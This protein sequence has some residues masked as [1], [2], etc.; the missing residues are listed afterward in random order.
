MGVIDRLG[1][2]AKGTVKVQQQ[3]WEEGG[4]LEGQLER[5]RTGAKELA[6]SAEAAVREARIPAP[7]EAS[8]PA[9]PAAAPAPSPVDPLAAELARLELAFA[10][11]RM[12]RSELRRKQAEAHARLGGSDRRTL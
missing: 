6:Q 10:E 5:L 8:A 9:P 3:A 12:T 11:G 2:L 4:G 1:N 7:T